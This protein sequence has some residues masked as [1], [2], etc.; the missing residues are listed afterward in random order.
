MHSVADLVEP[1]IIEE[2]A[3]SPADFHMGSRIYDADEVNFHSYTD[4]EVVAR[5]GYKPGDKV[6]QLHTASLVINGEKLNWKCSCTSDV[7][8]LCKHLVATALA[9]WNRVSADTI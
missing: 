6:N 5:V 9:T 3:C 1:N 8:L 2:L 4:H 7:S